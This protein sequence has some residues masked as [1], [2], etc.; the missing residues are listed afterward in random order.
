MSEFSRTTKECLVSQLHPELYQAIQLYTRQHELGDIEAETLICCETVSQ[1]K[2]QRRLPAWL[3]EQN[4][5]IVY[6]GMLLTPQWL[7]W[8]RS[9][10][11]SGVSLN[12]ARLADIRVKVYT[13]LL[14]QDGGLEISGYFGNMAGQVRGY[15]GLGDG[16]AAEKFCAAVRE[17]V[18]KVNPPVRRLFG[19]RLD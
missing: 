16:P 10:D 5:T 17:E 15:I 18:A 8:V 9:G 1:K 14:T 19:W 2:S 3:G 6:T 4:D 13:S 7:I 12:A 11:D